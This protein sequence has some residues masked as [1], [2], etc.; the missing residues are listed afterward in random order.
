MSRSAIGK[1]DRTNPRQ[2][3]QLRPRGLCAGLALLL[4]APA[5]GLTAPGTV[6][7]ISAALRGSAYTASGNS[8]TPGMS[9][10][11]RDLRL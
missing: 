5:A 7:L 9:A 10:D 1:A 6:G 2:L 8:V 3:R 4:A 11:G